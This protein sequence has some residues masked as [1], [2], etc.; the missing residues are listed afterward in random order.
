MHDGVLY[1]LDGNDPMDIEFELEDNHPTIL[2]TVPLTEVPHENGQANFNIEV[3]APYIRHEGG[4]AA[5]W[6][7][8]WSFFIP[9]EQLVSPLPEHELQPT[10]PPTHSPLMSSWKP[11]NELPSDY[12]MEQAIADNLYVN[13]HGMEIHNQHQ[14]DRFYTDVSSGGGAAFLRMLQYTIEGDAIITDIIYDGDVFTVNHDSTRDKFS[15]DRIISTMT[16]QYL[17]LNDKS[18]STNNSWFL[19]NEQNIYAP[20]ES[21]SVLID[22]LWNLPSP[23]EAE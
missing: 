5:L 19:S 15:A 18:G 9:F 7:G 20:T 14:V 8:V 23:T 21:N 6:N 16:Y 3:G 2:S 13:I 17:V 12:S 22:G 4:I 10:T 11:L 1:G